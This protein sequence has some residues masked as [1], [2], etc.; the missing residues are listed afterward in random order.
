MPI[1]EVTISGR[2]KQ[3]DLARLRTILGQEGYNPQG[4]G[5][6]QRMMGTDKWQYRTNEEIHARLL[7]IIG[8]TLPRVSITTV[9][10]ARQ[11]VSLDP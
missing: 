7:G 5:N 3:L 1:Y 6:P 2:D 10:E 9:P 4:F 8:T 11:R